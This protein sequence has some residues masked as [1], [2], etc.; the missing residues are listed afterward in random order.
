MYVN[1]GG[2]GIFS[3]QLGDKQTVISQLHNVHSFK[4]PEFHSIGKYVERKFE[5][6]LL[7]ST[8][9]DATGLSGVCGDMTVVKLT[10][11]ISR[12]F[13]CNSPP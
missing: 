3:Q 6:F 11:P 13:G 2:N 8:S 5:I 9:L 12:Y 10:F 4:T 7:R 1:L